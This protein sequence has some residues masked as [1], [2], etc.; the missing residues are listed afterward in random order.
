MCEITKTTQQ[1]PEKIL[2]LLVASVTVLFKSKFKFKFSSSFAMTLNFSH[3]GIL[4][5]CPTVSI[6]YPTLKFKSNLH[7]AR[8]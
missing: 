2:L 1:N 4:L 5:P 6:V 8:A 7:Q 3:A